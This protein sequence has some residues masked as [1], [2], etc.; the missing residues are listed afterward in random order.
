MNYEGEPELTE[1]QKEAALADYKTRNHD[2]EEKR[3]IVLYPE[4]V[5]FRE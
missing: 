2:W 3:I 4:D 1:A 5:E